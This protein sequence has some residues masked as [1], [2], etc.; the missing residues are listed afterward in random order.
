MTLSSQQKPAAKHTGEKEQKYA[1]ALLQKR[2]WW[3]TGTCRFQEPKWLT[4]HVKQKETL[5]QWEP[6]DSETVQ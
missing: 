4:D 1:Q 3:E 2:S 5:P 6:F